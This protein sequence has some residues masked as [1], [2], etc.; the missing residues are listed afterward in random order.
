VAQPLVGP[1]PP[2]PA[3]WR[4]E[5]APAPH[6]PLAGTLQEALTLVATGRGVMLLCEPSA[7]AHRRDDIVYVPVEGLTESALGLVW[8]R[9]GESR[10]VRA[11]ADAISAGCRA[12]ARGKMTTTHA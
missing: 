7:A 4:A 2:A 9:G 1:A 6:G 11:L 8:A 5:Q 12:R 3:Y 10:G